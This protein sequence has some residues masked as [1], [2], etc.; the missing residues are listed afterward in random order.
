M[1]LQFGDTLVTTSGFTVL[2]VDLDNAPGQ[3]AV[4]SG[5]AHVQGSNG[6]LSVDLHGGENV[7]LNA[8]DPSHYTLAESI[9]PD[10]WDAWNSDRDQ[11]LTTE[12]A[13]QTPA[14]ASLGQGQNPAWSDL[15]A[16]GNWYQVPGQ[17][18]VWS[19]YD[20]SNAGFD[21]YG[22]GNWMYTP[23]Y[24]YIWASG[25][26]WGYLPF[27]CGAWNFYNSFGWGWAPGMG[28]CTP[29]W[30]MGFYG[31]PNIGYAPPSYRVITRPIVPHRP[32]TG[33]PVAMVAVNRK[34]T[35]LTPGLPARD[36]ST[37]VTIAGKSVLPMGTLPSRAGFQHNVPAYSGVRTVVGQ[38]NGLR[39]GYSRPVAANPAANS[40]GYHPNNGNPGGFAAG[41]NNS[42]AAPANRSSGGNS[43]G[44]SPHPSGGGGGG[45]SGGGGGSHPSGGG[46][47]GYSG[48]GGGGGG[49]HSSGGGGG[50]G[51]SS[52]NSGGHH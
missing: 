47:G 42:S 44:G 26:P 6:A 27:Q 34:A 24:G 50:G 23:G 20:A 16:N 5:N 43:G 28:G 25:Y 17:G 48:G 52:S 9:E 15:D 19:P 36:R 3:L 29:W 2:R 18:Y 21:P 30:G 7:A 32:I 49:S 12:A 1:N 8:T 35:F 46:G 40:G 22:N 45:Y 33:R 41:R 10:S 51:S 11:A 4:F 14:S 13:N 38:S 39:P 37:M 31:G